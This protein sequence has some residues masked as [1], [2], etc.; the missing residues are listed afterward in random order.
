MCPRGR[1][2]V[3]STRRVEI[4]L[5]FIG[6]GAVVER[7]RG[8]FRGGV[9]DA[10]LG[11]RFG[12]NVLPEQEDEDGNFGPATGAESYR[13]AFQINLWGTSA[14]FRE[15][16]RYLLAIAELDTSAD[17]G[18]H[19]HHDDLRTVDGRTQIDLIVRKIPE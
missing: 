2:L 19:Q 15:L 11:K 9:P 5:S 12:F 1:E 8:V 3:K 13:G 6:K 14:D 7:P 10:K 18:F 17:P 4:D 16:G